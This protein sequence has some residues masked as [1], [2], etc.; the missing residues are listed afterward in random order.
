MRSVLYI[1]E[2]DKESLTFLKAF[3]LNNASYKGEFFTNVRKL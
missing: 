3:F 2:K 1:Y